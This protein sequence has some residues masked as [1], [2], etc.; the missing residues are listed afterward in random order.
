ML[1]QVQINAAVATAIATTVSAI[2]TGM[3]SIFLKKRADA[4]L[5]TLKSEQTQ[6]LEKMKAELALENKMRGARIDYEYDARKRLYNEVEPVLFSAHLA[7]SS[8]R[9]RLW[10]FVERIREGKISQDSEK[11]WMRDSYYQEST[12]YRL[13]LPMIHHRLL[14]RK[15]SQ[16]DFTLEPL[17]GR[18]FMVLGIFPDIFTAHFDLARVSKHEIPYDP[19]AAVTQAEGDADPGKYLFQGLVRGEVERLISLMVVGEPSHERPIEWFQ[20][21]QQLNLKG[22]ELDK[23]Y[24]PVRKLLSRFHPE[25]HPVLWR[26]LVSFLLL[27][28]FYVRAKRLDIEEYDE[29]VEKPKWSRLDYRSAREREVTE[30]RLVHQHFEAAR[31]HIRS[32]IVAEYATL[33]TAERTPVADKLGNGQIRKIITL[34]LLDALG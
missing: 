17:I 2:L 18:K 1:G 14:S 19:Y 11:T 22:S 9:G 3:F 30:E 13:F 6:I 8:L 15:M 25:T 23:A 28:E 29:C 24:A 7:A 26:I 10:P 31:L 34:V 33:L 5:E 27:S 12:A 20:F 16:L 21:E 4:Y 32:R